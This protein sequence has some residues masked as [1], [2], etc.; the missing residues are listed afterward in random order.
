METYQTE[1]LGGYGSSKDKDDMKMKFM[2]FG[3]KRYFS[4]VDV[5]SHPLAEAAFLERIG[6]FGVFAGKLDYQITKDISADGPLYGALFTFANSMLRNP[7]HSNSK[8]VIIR[9]AAF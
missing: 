1:I 8:S 6:G 7:A 3:I 9:T 2:T 4:P 5:T